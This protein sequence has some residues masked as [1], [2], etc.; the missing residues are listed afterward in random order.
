MPVFAFVAFPFDIKSK[1]IPHNWFCVCVCVMYITLSFIHSSSRERLYCFHILVI[2][3]SWT[4]EY[5][6]L[7]EIIIFFLMSKYPDL[8]LISWGAFILFSIVTCDI[9]LHSHQQCTCVLFFFFLIFNFPNPHQNSRLIFLRITILKGM[10]WYL[11]VILICI[12]LILSVK[13]STFSYTYGPVV[14]LLW[15]KMFLQVLCPFK[16]SFYYSIIY[17]QFFLLCLIYLFIFAFEIYEFP[18]YLGY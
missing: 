15:K 13:L 18:I 2:M 1:K 14:C 8:F 5:K 11:T 9:K 3:L 12:S 7:F 6:Y 17:L 16:K 4:L 10:R